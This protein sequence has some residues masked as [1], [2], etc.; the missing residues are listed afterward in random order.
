MD[1]GWEVESNPLLSLVY[2]VI[3][4]ILSLKDSRG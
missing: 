1:D 4:L 3:V 2:C